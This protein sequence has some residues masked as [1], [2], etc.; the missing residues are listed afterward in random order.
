MNNADIAHA[1]EELADLLEL[2][3]ENA[4]R[5]RAYRGGAKAILELTEPVADILADPSREL[6]S[7]AGI[8]AT[9]AEKCAVMVAQ[10]CLPQLDE[11]RA[12]TPPV[13][14]KMTRIPGLGAKKAALLVQELGIESLEELRQACQEGRVQ[15]LKGF[16][17]K[18]EQQILAG[19]EIAEAASQ[20]LRIDQGES[21]VFRLR[22]HLQACTSIEQ[23]EFAGSFRRGRE[24]V[25]D[26]DVLVVSQNANEVMDRLESFPGRVSTTLRGD[27]KMSIRVDDQ[28]QV[29]LRVVPAESFGA[30]L[31]YF[32]GSKEHNV[33]IRGRAR[34][35]GLTVNEYGVARLD[36]PEEY[37]A[38][39]TEEELYAALGLQ[40]IAPEL[41]EGRHEIEWAEQGAAPHRLVELGDIVSDLHM[42]TTATDG[43]NTLEEMVAAARSRGLLYIAITD[44]SKRVS[45]ARGLDET[46]LLAQWQQIDAFNARQSDGFRVLKGIECD[47]LESGPMDLPNE[48]LAEADWVIASVHY[49][50]KQS[51]VQIT[52]RI[53]GALRNPHVDIIAHPTGRLLGAR[54]AYDVDLQAVF[55]AAAEQGK[56]LELNAS[57]RRLDLSEENLLAAVKHGIPIAINTDA[58]S[59]EGLDVMRYGVQQGRR[60]GLEPQQV[61]NTWSLETLLQWLEHE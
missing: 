35:L 4:F 3:G 52:D 44:H 22:S 58:H 33:A 11:L 55:E 54:P 28:F 51:R 39:R 49:G 40:W 38:G 50:Q 36:A 25:G 31:Q 16:A 26:I 34:K 29:D 30:A 8:G 6:T 47:I 57:P 45:M 17:A 53:L 14:L 13:L 7:F 10:N 60:A 2:R 21:L 59:I 32:T 19:L 61:I 48:V 41:R 37:I 23:L 12:K 56:A 1:F 46:R 43:G 42:H 15:K 20:R 5:I 18:T 27:T 9:L 24:T